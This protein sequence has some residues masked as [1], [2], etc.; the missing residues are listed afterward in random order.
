MGEGMARATLATIE[1]NSWSVGG[2]LLTGKQVRQ[3]HEALPR[4]RS[5]LRAIVDEPRIG[6]A[7][8]VLKRAGLIRFD[9]V[10]WQRTHETED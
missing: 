3:V 9:G 5:Q 7:L 6:R 2:W 8:D 4:T 1:S 10:A